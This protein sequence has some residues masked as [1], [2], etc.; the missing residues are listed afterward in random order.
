VPELDELFS[1]L[2]IFGYR[3]AIS[4]FGVVKGRS[5]SYPR[6]PSEFGGHGLRLCFWISLREILFGSVGRPVGKTAASSPPWSYAEAPV[7]TELKLVR[8]GVS[9]STFG[10]CVSTYRAPVEQVFLRYIDDPLW[11][12]DDGDRLSASRI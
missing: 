11:G 8:F 5:E 2:S 12:S 1:L 3:L 7:C 4:Y 10:S 9:K 6:F